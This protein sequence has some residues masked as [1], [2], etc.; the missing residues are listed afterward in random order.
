MKDGIFSEM[1]SHT[2]ALKPLLLWTLILTLSVTV[3]ATSF[4]LSSEITRFIP[5]DCNRRSLLDV[6]EPAWGRY[7]YAHSHHCNVDPAIN[8]G[9][10]HHSPCTIDFR[11]GLSHFHD[12]APHNDLY[13]D[14][15]DHGNGQCLCAKPIVLYHY[16][17]EHSASVTAVP[18]AEESNSGSSERLGTAQV[19]GLAVGIAA[20][21]GIAILAIC[22]ARRKRRRDYPDVKTGF[23]PVREKDSWE[24]HPQEGP[25]NIFHISPPLHHARS[26][27]PPL[28]PPPAAR[29]RTSARTS[30][31]PGAIGL[32]ISRPQSTGT[33]KLPQQQQA[34]PTSRLLPAKPSL[35]SPK[36]VLSIKI[37]KID[38][39][40]SK[41]VLHSRQTP[42]F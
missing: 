34:R 4:N 12:E 22:L 7:S 40:R 39:L 35:S 32:A 41:K 30:W 25:A 16:K 36:P 15:A 33:P 38:L 18:G 20:A 14:N 29:T 11:G 31:W 24:F 21:V 8:G 42:R 17:V 3:T 26:P 19:A 28:Q 1:F 13:P 27:S 37:P 9:R 2:M 6:L 5:T 10:H 23:F